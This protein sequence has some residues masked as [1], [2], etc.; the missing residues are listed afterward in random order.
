MNLKLILFLLVIIF[1][2]NCNK[3]GKHCWQAF[4]PQGYDV[5]GLILCDKTKA[6]AEAAYPQ[7]WFYRS[8]EKKY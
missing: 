4:S 6:E 1:F 7:N 3:D 8:G 2:G 5:P